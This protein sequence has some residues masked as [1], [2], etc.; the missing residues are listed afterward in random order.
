[1]AAAVV[2]APCELE[3]VR[4]EKDALE[5]ELV[6]LKGKAAESE[7]RAGQLA[8]HVLVL[9]DLLEQKKGQLDFIEGRLE[10]LGMD[11]V[12]VQPFEADAVADREHELRQAAEDFD[13]RLQFL[14]QGVERRNEL[15]AESLRALHHISEALEV[16]ETQ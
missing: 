16:L 11:P 6:V 7:E 10:S 12:A 4:K 3:T 9:E 13:K 5:L 1:V 14:R 2:A 8:S 15:L